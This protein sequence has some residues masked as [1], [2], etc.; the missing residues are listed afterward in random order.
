[1]KKMFLDFRFLAD[2]NIIISLTL[3]DE[4]KKTQVQ[5]L[6]TKMATDCEN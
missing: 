6:L 2:I 3:D 5:I 1:M 4:I